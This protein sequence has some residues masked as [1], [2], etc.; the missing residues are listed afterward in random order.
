MLALAV[1]NGSSPEH[2]GQ[3]MTL[4]ERHEEREA[5][6]AYVLAMTEFKRNPVRIEKTRTA[7]IRA[8][9]GQSTHSYKYANL[10]DVCEQI[11]GNL[12]A[13]GISHQW[14]TNQ[15]DG[16]VKV[17]CT[18]THELGHSHSTTLFSGLDETGSKNKLQALGSAVSY[19]Q[20]Y[21]LLAVC[22]IAVD[23]ES[24]DDAGGAT[25]EERAELR[26][27][28]SEMRGNRNQRPADV[29]AQRQQQAGAPDQVL[30][31]AAWDA[32]N[33]GHATFGPYWRGL[34]PEQRT[35][36]GS[37]LPALQIRATENGGK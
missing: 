13:C 27:A 18:L 11:V 31:V 15:Q 35:M 8:K 14:T 1:V 5:R 28:A 30:L 33:K 19:L 6:K 26:Q 3:L 7:K 10:A 16:L 25:T 36:L 9:D 23:D 32:A 4:L 12:A 17:T 20:R 24:D 37:E 29:A 21:T 22:G 2:V 34:T